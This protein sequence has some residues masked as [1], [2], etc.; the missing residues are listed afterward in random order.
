MELGGK[1]LGGTTELRCKLK[2]H[3]QSLHVTQS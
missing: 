2:G 3:L 1:E